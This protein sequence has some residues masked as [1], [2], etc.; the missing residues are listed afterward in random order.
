[1]STSTELDLK[2]YYVYVLADPTN[3]DKI[4]YV[5]KGTSIRGNDHLKEARRDL[6]KSSP[7]LDQIRK[8]ETAGELPKVSVVGRFDTEQEAF[9]VEATLIHWVYGHENLTNI[10]AG[11]GSKYIRPK[12]QGFSELQG[13]D[14]PN[15]IKIS[16]VPSTGYLRDIMN[17]HQNLGHLEMA[18]DLLG[19]LQKRKLSGLSD[20]AEAIDGGRYIALV[21]KV[22][23][24]A[25]I[26]L[27]L[28]SATTH[29]IILNVKPVSN[30][31]VDRIAFDKFVDTIPNLK[32]RAKGSYAKFSHWQGLRLSVGDHED[33]LLQVLDTIKRL[34]NP[35][36]ES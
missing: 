29:R 20:E 31:K 36:Q 13:I 11:H 6:E 23:D 9:A 10:Q 32:S 12:A 24:V 1:M 34:K 25:N 27:Q 17:A 16:G 35:I 18:T 2:P 3:D 22:N 5:G 14:I 33:I 4:F 26:V 19:F 28:T 15:R 30:R 21:V 7:K 8:I